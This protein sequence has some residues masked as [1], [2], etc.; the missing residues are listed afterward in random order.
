MKTGTLILAMH[1]TPGE[2]AV[3]ERVRD[4]LLANGRREVF[5]GFHHGSP[6]CLDVFLDMNREGVDTYCILPLTV[7]EGR[8]TVW[9]MPEHLTLPDNSGSWTMIGEHDVATRFSTAVGADVGLGEAIARH[10]G[11]VE[12]D[13]GVILVCRGSEL[14]FAERTIGL[15]AEFLRD[16]GW[17]VAMAFAVHGH[18]DISDALASMEGYPRLRIVPFFIDPDSRSLRTILSE[19]HR[20]HVL[21]PCISEHEEFLRVFDRKVPDG[22]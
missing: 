20:E 3:A 21:E 18:P 17:P 16:L 5:V 10:P 22:W 13:T 12:P 14:S 1:D 15:Y 11:P 2:R 9:K 4:H 8:Q 7:F 19:V 6:D